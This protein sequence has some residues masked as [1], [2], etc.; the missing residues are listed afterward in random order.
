[1]KKRILLSE[2]A[3]VANSVIAQKQNN[4]VNGKKVLSGLKGLGLSLDIVNDWKE[5]VEPH[6]L[7]Q[8]PG[9]TLDFNLDAK[10][11]KAEYNELAAFYKTNRG[12]LTYDEPTAEELEAVRESYRQYAESEKQIEAYQLAHDVVNGLNRLKDLGVHIE[13]YYAINLSPIFVQESRGGAIEVY[14]KNLNDAVL[15]LK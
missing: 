12:N 10:G 1:M 11:I 7:K 3:T 5:D 9:S 15:N 14:T 6:F 4:F 13:A 8:F 2:N